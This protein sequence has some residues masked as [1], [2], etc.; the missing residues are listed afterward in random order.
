MGPLTGL[1]VVEL[2]SIGP[3]PLCA[4]LL[5]DLG[6]D[7]I[8]IDRTEPSGLGVPLDVKFD[9]AGRNRRSVA[10][11]I[12]Q[13]AGRDAALRLIDR[14]DMLIEGWRPGV[15]E[16]LGLGPEACRA[17]NPGLVFGRMTGFGQTGPLSQ[18]AG[19]DINYIALTGALH[20]I[21]T[22]GE[23]GKP[24]PPLNLVGDY[25]GGAL[26]L[27]FGLMAAIFERS[28]S[29]QGQVV[30]AAMVDGAAS[31]MSIFYGMSAS[32]QWAPA[33]RAANLLDG[34]APFYDTYA[35]ADARWI[36]LGPLEPKFFAELVQRLALDRS[37]IARQY[38]RRCWPELRA[39]IGLAVA[40]KTRDEWSA[41]LEGTDVCYAPVLSLAEAPAHR[42][43]QDR[44]GF[45]TVAGVVQPAPAPRFSR[46]AADPPRPAVKPGSHTDSILAEAG[47]SN[48]EIA[49]LRQS[50]VAVGAPPRRQQMPAAAPPRGR[51][52]LGSGPALAHEL[53]MSDAPT[54]T[55][56]PHAAPAAARAAASLIVL[57]DSP[58]GPEVL[59]LRRAE[60]AGDQN[61]GATVFPGGLLDASDQGH[62]R[63]CA[64]LD[65]ASASLR[66][67]LPQDGLHYWVA[68]VRECFEEAGLLLA[69][70]ASG[71]TVDLQALPAVELLAMRHALHANQIGMDQVCERLGVRLSVGQLAYFSHWITPIGLPK[72]FDTRFFIAVAPAGQS[73]VHD[74]KETVDL[75]WLTPAEALDRQRGLKLMNVTEITLKQLAGFASAQAGVDWARAQAAIPMTRPRVGRTAKGERRPLNLGDWAFAELGRIDP[76]GRGTASVELV[77]GAPV[78]LS[79]RVLRVTAGNG[80]LMTGPG[81]NSYFLGA[82]GSDDWALLDPGP[83]DAAHIAALLAAAPGKITRILVTHTH[84]DHSPAAAAIAAATGAPTLGQVAA[85]PEWQDTAF[86]PSQVLVDGDRLVLGAGVTLRVVHTPGHASNHLC[87]LLEEEK[88]LF[89]GDHLMQ[90]STVVINPPDGDMAVYLASLAKLQALDL[91][92]LAP[93]HGFL[94]DQPQAVVAKTIAHRLGREAK[95]LAGLGPLAS[96]VAV[97]EA[98]L[99][100]NVYADTPSALHAMALRSLRAHLL[101]LQADGRVAAQA[102]GAW[103]RVA[104]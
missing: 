59:L 29:G 91:D 3:G 6:A 97:T 74:A 24:V 23:H 25:G 85:Y 52:Q 31:L 93:G 90:G 7:V 45:A 40:G 102:G 96:A 51:S 84:K 28:K 9:V 72:I 30:D 22:G 103:L 11:D 21:G 67:G 46:S 39:A 101:K 38:D 4:M 98:A 48:D 14:A 64:G 34:G 70:D 44:A 16:R 88:L 95:V 42:H 12:K 18:A 37:F 75:L 87:Y 20:A 100:A 19:H 33:Q 26:Y 43:A 36:S 73:A 78:W 63:L 61:G 80:S 94:I 60:R 13:A 99:L 86:Q 1:R 32:G 56:P 69:T 17:R 35:T 8:R 81:T 41:L 68:A 58:R 83:D 50:G 57:R 54:L 89:T 47:F 104:A 71:Q 77:P 5:A 2:A 79:P 66:L 15:A 62:Y 82:P 92:W 65:D 27:A 10:L 55:L 49:A 76:E 53:E